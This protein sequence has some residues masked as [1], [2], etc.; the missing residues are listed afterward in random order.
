MLEKKNIL[1]KNLFIKLKKNP[2][3]SIILEGGSNQ[4]RLDVFKILVKILNCSQNGCNI[5]NICKSID[6]F[7]C[8]D[9]IIF[10]S[11]ETKIENIR[12]LKQVLSNLP[13]NNYRFI[14]F[15]EAHDLNINCLNS[16]LKVL[17]EPPKNNIFVFLVSQRESLLTTIL[18]RSFVFNLSFYKEKIKIKDEFQSA[19][20]FIYTGKN[21]FKL[22]KKEKFSIIE[23]KNLIKFFQQELILSYLKNNNNSLFLN[24]ISPHQF[25]KIVNTLNIAQQS[26]NSKVSPNLVLEWFVVKIFLILHSKDIT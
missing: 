25:F 24:N 22:N 7:E 21:F 17:E 14:C 18:S 20:K 3:S 23:I 11:N 8:R 19:I 9:I 1:L 10:E 6:N 12:E 15:K 4:F 2:P 16:L 13:N 5:C 26:L